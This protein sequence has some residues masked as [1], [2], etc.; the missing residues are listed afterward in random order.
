MKTIRC[1]L[2]VLTSTVLLAGCSA[3]VDDSA[4]QQPTGI[5]SDA[6]PIADATVFTLDNGM[7]VI[8]VQNRA[9]PMVT[10]FTI[11]R[12]GSRYED[13]STNGSAHFLEHLLFNGTRKRTQKQLYDE[14]DFYGGYNNAST[15]P[16]FTNYM[17]LM[18]KEYIAEGMDI[19]ADMLF[20]STLP[21]AKF[22]KERGIVIEEIGKDSDR[23]TY[24]VEN[25]FLKVFFRGT[26]YTRPT[27]GT[28]STISHLPRDRVM[29]FYKTWY[30]P[31]NMTL[32]VIGD[33]DT[34]AMIALV[35]EKYGKAAPGPLPDVPE[36]SLQVPKRKTIITST[37]V[38]KFPADKK[39]LTI[40]YPLPAPSEEGFQALELLTEF[41]GGDQTAMLQ[42]KFKEGE[43]S[44]LVNSISA[45]LG[46]NRDFSWL[47]I[48]AELPLE[49]DEQKVIDLIQETIEDLSRKGVDE[50]RVRQALI[51]R[52]ANEIFLQ[53]KLHY[54]GMMKSGYLAAGGYS[55][56]RDY[57]AGLQQVRAVDIRRVA[58]AHLVKVTPVITLM[59]PPKKDD[60]QDHSRSPNTYH[61]EKLDNG[62]EVVVQYNPD[63]PVVGMHLLARDP[64][65]LAGKDRWGSADILQRAL[66]E[67]GTASRPEQAFRE[68]AEAIGAELK[69]YDSPWIPYDDYYHSPLF[70]YIRL[71][72]VDKDFAAGVD[73]LADV[74][75]NAQLGDTHIANA[76][77]SVVSLAERA[78]TSTPAVAKKRFYDELL[79]ENPGFGHE[80][81]EADKL[82][83]LPPEAVRELYRTLYAPDNLILT[84]SGNIP[85][86][87]AMQ[88]VR[89]SFS[90]Q[91]GEPV[92]L[93]DLSLEFGRFG[94]TV[95][96]Q[97]GKQQSYIYLANRFEVAE[98]DVPVLRVLMAIFSDR[99]AFQLRE[100][101]GLAYSI[102]ASSS[103]LAGLR[104]YTVRMGTR[105]QNIDAAVQ[106]IRKQVQAMR[107]TTIREDEVRKTVNSLLG[108]HG[109]R[110]LDRAGKAYYIAMQVM[111][112]K[113]ADAD[114]K[115]AELLKSV[116]ARD[117]NR[118]K[119]A[120][121]ARDDHLVV[122]VE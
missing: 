13:A 8:L 62:L 47:K 69:M 58:L 117:I 118:L 65:R 68:A 97:V 76:R 91:W 36:I 75:R 80:L 90:G 16:D 3:K 7:E 81:G 105:P 106:G 56:L 34:E 96:E 22:E 110:R 14:M 99:I 64:A 73:L 27:L 103:G 40:G 116:T 63:S 83:E 113:S 20:N 48:S 121:F 112:G 24:Q 55:F 70:A 86:E 12:T 37:A 100:K 74:T 57:M 1:L 122:I 101:Q 10:A 43:N 46:F 23:P 88:A 6:G 82:R 28:V 35:R 60:Q 61:T 53:E 66:L 31:N 107:S 50:E 85:P 33:F 51:K 17:I 108:R 25:E 78:A 104:W 87:Q 120:V 39:Y 84:I 59:K 4:V 119:K 79:V 98:K 72:V 29:Q 5:R 15:G 9:N 115:S 77:K 45:G 92:E 30:V 21:P 26:P 41:L 44:K 42:M 67:G 94:R 52:A 102:G 71:K 18:P 95:R 32:M 54:Y 49:A 111:Q 89:A 109:M 19:Q 93:A 2:A 38:G 114:E 11:V